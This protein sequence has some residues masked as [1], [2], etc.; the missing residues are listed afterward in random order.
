MCFSYNPVDGLVFLKKLHFRETIPVF[1]KNG[2]E[3][4]PHK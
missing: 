4:N 3:T 2:I 1:K